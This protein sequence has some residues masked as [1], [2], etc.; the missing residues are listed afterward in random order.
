MIEEIS[1]GPYLVAMNEGVLTLTFSRPEMRNA[2]PTEAI[3]PLAELFERIAADT[4]VRVVL[5]KAKGP[6]FGGGGDVSGMRASLDMSREERGRSYWERLDRASAMVRNWCAIPQPIVAAVRG[7]VAGAAMMYTLGADFVIGD[8]TTYFLCAHSLIGLSPDS[9]LS[10]LL[11][12]AIGQKRATE[13]FLSGRKVL[14]HEALAFGLMSRV[15]PSEEVDILAEKQARA[16]ASG[17]RKILRDAK[18]MIAAAAGNGLVAQLDL[19]RDKVSE[20]VALGDFE[21]GVRAFMEKRRAKFA[22]E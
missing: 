4:S 10:F 20:N 19:E 3:V 15:V 14:A 5:V 2:I 9:G 1:Q 16:L 13:M 22:S 12:R 18:A 17:P 6:D 11:P 7:S 21:E 8:E